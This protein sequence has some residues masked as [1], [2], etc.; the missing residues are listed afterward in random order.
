MHEIQGR[1]SLGNKIQSASVARKEL[2]G[3]VELYQGNNRSFMLEAWGDASFLFF[4]C[5]D[6]R[7]S[8]SCA[9][10]SL[11]WGDASS[12]TCNKIT[13]RGTKFTSTEYIIRYT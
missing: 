11:A 9:T 8:L 5:Y 3:F 6:Q 2:L 1:S 7:A 10:A 12:I 13:P 4:Y